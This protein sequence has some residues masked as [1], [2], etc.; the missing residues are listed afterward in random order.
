MKNLYTERLYLRNWTIDDLNDLYAY[1]Q[2]NEVGSNAGW[3]PHFSKEEAYQALKEYINQENHW[4]IVLKKE[5]KVIGS[6]KLN[7]DNNRGKYYA[8]SISFALSPD[9][10]ANGFMTEAVK[11]VIKYAFEELKID[12]L[13]AFH[14][15]ENK[16]SQRVIEKCGFEYEITLKQ[17]VKRYDG[18]LFDMVCYCILKSDYYK[19]R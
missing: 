10:W 19:T 11:E 3:K 5:N 17:S 18:E 6:I 13:S 12:L 7:P 15:P 2:K 1:S 4:A 8:K 9:Y 16:Q 14:Y